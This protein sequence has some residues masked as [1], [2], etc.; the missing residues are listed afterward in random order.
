MKN[1]QAFSLI[2]LSIVILIIGIIIVGA[3]QGSRLVRQYKLSIAR[4]A[5]QSSPVSSIP[6]LFL[7]LD[8]SSDKSFDNNVDDGI[9]IANLYDIN[10]QTSSKI[11]FVQ[12]TRINQPTYKDGIINNLPV[13]S[14]DGVD[15]VLVSANQM[16]NLDFS[17]KNETTVFFVANFYNNTMF[18][19]YLSFEGTSTGER[20]YFTSFSSMSRF[21]YVLDI[22]NSING[23]SLLGGSKIVTL[24]NRNLKQSIYINGSSSAI[25][26]NTSAFQGF[27]GY[28]SIGAENFYL[29]YFMG[30]AKIEVAEVII[31][32]RGLG[33]E[34][35]LAV[36]NYLS[37]KWGIK[38]SVSTT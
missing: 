15:D 23:G 9:G 3:T 4:S 28:M 38:I 16:S 27:S 13:I 30:Y 32:K 25:A 35:R 2:E 24:R 34:E 6:D 21:T 20:F 19:G 29:T 10:P 36:E 11:N 7:W 5:T 8:S 37:K 31:F 12:S 18:P 26:N 33:I 17:S 14:F 22:T 1:P